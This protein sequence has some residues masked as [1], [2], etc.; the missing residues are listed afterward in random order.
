MSTTPLSVGDLVYS[1]FG[2]MCGDDF[3]TVVG[4]EKTPWGDNVWI[5]RSD[6]SLTAATISGTCT[7]KRYTNFEGAY[8]SARGATKIGS[9]KVTSVTDA[10]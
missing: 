2:V 10:D 9:Y 6:F 4:F 5:R 8:L 7:A 1:N 3:G